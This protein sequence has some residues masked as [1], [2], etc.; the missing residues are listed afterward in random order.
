M[1][2]SVQARAVLLLALLAFPAVA[3]LR[4]PVALN[5]PVKA[6][7]VPKCADAAPAHEGIKG[8]T[9][10][11]FEQ[12]KLGGGT[13]CN[14]CIQLMEQ[15]I[16]A[17]LNIILN[18]GVVGTCGELCGQLPKKLEAEACNLVCDAAGI[19]GFIQALKHADLDPVYFCELTEKLDVPI[20][21]IQDCPEGNPNC[22]TISQLDVSPTSGPVGTDFKFSIV[23]N[24]TA[25]VGT[26]EIRF[27][28]CP[29]GKD[30]ECDGQSTFVPNLPAGQY[31]LSVEF[32]T[33][34]AEQPPTPGEYT[35]E[36]EICE[37]LC[38]PNPPRNPHEYNFGQKAVKFTI[39]KDE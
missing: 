37:G 18:S 27:A 30:P 32:D 16:N 23:M 7:D 24:G 9:V 6:A 11:L 22:Q 1:K 26:S 34:Q 17:L 13:L 15:S 21:P 19:Y 36:F 5:T 38:M 10:N 2:L 28:L 29:P 33:S 31:G 39:T 3:A 35:F 25:P 12:T 20:C 4:I 14:L 8:L